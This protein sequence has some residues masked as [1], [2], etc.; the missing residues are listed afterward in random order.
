MSYVSEEQSVENIENNENID[1]FIET[2]YESF[3]E[4]DSNDE[5]QDQEEGIEEM[6]IENYGD[7]QYVDMLSDFLLELREEFK[8]SGVGCTYVATRLADFMQ[9]AV[10]LKMST[11]KSFM[12]ERG[13]TTESLQ[14]QINNK[15]SI[16]CDSAQKFSSMK[17]LDNYISSKRHF[18]APEE[19]T[20][21]HN[22]ST[23]KIDT[24]EY[25]PILRTLQTITEKDDVLAHIFKEEDE[26]STPSSS[27]I[28]NFRDGSIFKNSIFFQENPTALQINL[29]V[30]EFVP[31]N[32]LG[33]KVKKG[34]ITAVY[35]TL[36]N[37]P[38][39]YR[40]RLKDIHLV[41]LY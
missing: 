4:I 18:V 34:K 41:I 39:K 17:N 23:N 6:E 2:S 26:E 38:R 3:D 29:Y 24:Y 14:N 33:N 1:S 15:K 5:A 7:T 31:C 13:Y 40:S 19:I 16:L 35:F 21:G 25:V 8:V 9:L 27:L 22:H 37:I 11:V 32:K 28:T 20:L 36:G 30:D 10:E 12:D